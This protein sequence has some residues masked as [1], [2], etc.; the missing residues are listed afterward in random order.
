[1]DGAIGSREKIQR[2]YFSTTICPFQALINLD[3]CTHQ[4]SLWCPNPIS[5][6]VPLFSIFILIEC[7]K[8]FLNTLY[9]VILS[10]L[11]DFNLS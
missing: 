10:S 2:H 7:N 6:A 5:N 9:G 8:L 11:A 1:M 3:K 4:L